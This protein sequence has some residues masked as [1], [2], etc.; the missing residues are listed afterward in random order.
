MRE[1]K[2][3]KEEISTYDVIKYDIS[4]SW[5]SP[6]QLILTASF[7]KTQTFNKKAVQCNVFELAFRRPYY[8]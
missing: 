7:A 8:S 5:S 1:E 4:T 3:A 2:T 6:Q